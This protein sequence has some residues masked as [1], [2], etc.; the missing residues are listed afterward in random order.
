MY[1]SWWKTVNGKRQYVGLEGQKWVITGTLSKPRKFF[2]KLI[3]DNGGEI[4]SSISKNTTVLLAGEN[5]GS[6][7]AKAK[8]LGINIINEYEI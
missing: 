1:K 6:K 4:S 5:A 2:V 3:E 7:L 8:K